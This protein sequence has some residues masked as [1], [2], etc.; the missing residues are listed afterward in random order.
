M[1]SVLKEVVN[2][3]LALM[4]KDDLM[5]EL[6][7]AYNDGMER[8]MTYVEALK[9]QRNVSCKSDCGSGK[10][11]VIGE[12]LFNVQQAKGFCKSKGISAERVEFLCDYNR[13]KNKG[14]GKYQYN[15][16]YSLI[17]VG[18]VP[19]SM[20]DKGDYSSIIAKMEQEDGYPPVVRANN[21]NCLKLTLS[22][23]KQIINGQMGNGCIV[24]A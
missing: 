18:P 5:D 10:I 21:G 17:I 4:T 16:D 7:E 6:L 20:R 8:L 3:E 12:A 2:M 14:I 13:L 22:T 9:E 23:F 15:N 19:H 24:A 1:M 11:L